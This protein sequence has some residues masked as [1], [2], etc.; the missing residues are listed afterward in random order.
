MGPQCEDG[1]T[2]IANE[3]LEALCRIPLGNSEAQIFFFVL[4]KTY[5]WNRKQDN[6]SIGQIM[7]GTGISRRM[8][9]YGIQNLESKKLLNVF[10]CRGR[11]IKNEINEISIQK[12][13]E[14]WVVQEKSQQYCE[15]LKKRRL[16]YQKSKAGVVQENLS[17]ARNG[18]SSARNSEKV[19]Q[20]TVNDEQFLAPTK[21]TTTKDNTKDIKPNKVPKKRSDNEPFVLPDWIPEKSWDAFVEM[22]KKLKK[23]MTDYAKQLAI[24]DLLK[25]R[26]RGHPP[27]AVLNQ[28]TLHS[29]QGLF[30]IKGKYG[31]K[32][33]DED[34]VLDAVF[35]R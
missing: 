6:I 7:E 27:E 25:L 11:G 29:W 19:V 3:L 21:D 32:Q 16:A 12:N 23:P 9:I 5:G 20:E 35:G 15:A 31:S 1:Y 18:I 34:A 17:S 30:E 8:V 33:P 26:E 4:R 28:S 13:H 2:R 24:N 22:R 10:R 14:L